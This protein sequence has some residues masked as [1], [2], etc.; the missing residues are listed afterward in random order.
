MA[1]IPIILSGGS[2]TRL[3]PVSRRSKPKQFLCFGSDRSL[4]QNT[5]LR[6]RSAVFDA[7]PIVVGSDDHRFLLAED[8]LEIGIEADILLEP[9]ARNSCAAI[10]AGC[11]QARRRSPDAKVLV[12]AAD[13]FIPDAGA[14]AEAVERVKKDVDAGRLVTFGVKPTQPSTAYGYILP[15]EPLAVACNVERFVEKP[16]RDIARA[17]VADGYLWNSGNFAFRADVLLEEVDRH[18]PNVVK[19]VSDAF[20][21][22][23]RDLDFLR[24]DP[25][26]FRAAPSIAFDNAVMERTAQAAVMPVN[27]DWSDVGSWDAVGGTVGS[28]EDGN[29]IIGSGMVMDGRNNLVHSEG[30][31]TAAIGVDDMVVVATRDCVL[32]TPKHRAEEVK[33]LVFRLQEEERPEANESLKIFRPWGNYE[34][35][36]I[37]DGYQV[38]RIVVKPG[39][40]LSLQKHRFRAEHW[41]VVQGHPEVEINGAV[42]TLDPN[43]S[44]YVPLGAVHRLSNRGREPVVLI[45]IQTGTYLG[46]DDIIRLEDTY[47][48]VAPKEGQAA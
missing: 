40:I 34:R 14:F 4:F 9:E 27:Y 12:L 44:I 3:W 36:D 7:R 31:L 37:D 5:V 28:D 19:A 24:L 43:Q 32:V 38:K 23:T 18:E 1:F 29:A 17:Y 8:L 48:R 46:E 45:E 15:G 42:Q 22:A 20:D 10:V 39:G 21:T 25:E 41:V 11:L 30:R 13:H 35:L 6:C 26:S 2:G 33:V 16:I 47:N